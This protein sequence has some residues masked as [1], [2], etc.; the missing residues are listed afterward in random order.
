MPSGVEN[1][2]KRAVRS[3]LIELSMRTGIFDRSLFSLY[4]YMFSPSQL[5]FLTQCL[6]EVRNVPG[7][8]V[9]IGCAHG[10]TTVF[11]RKF[12]NENGIAKDYWALDT[13]GGFVAEHVDYE[14]ARRD[15]TRAIS[16]IFVTNKRSWFE[17]SLK[18]SG[19]DAVNSVEGDATKFDFDRIA[20]IAFALL[21]VDL[22]LPI[23]DILPKL[24]RNL[25]PG[26]IILIDDC[27]PHELW[28]GALAA[29][30]EFAMGNGIERSIVLDKLGVIRK[31]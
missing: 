28:D 30:E 12:M 8:C 19:V 31:A 26:G 3:C 9:E 29:Y 1:P 13:F 10:R 20:P 5:V 22:Y 24:Y 2:F 23:K 27:M 14:V 21:D 18:I 25:S 6:A 16:Q 7:C 17:H 11:L 15:K 4:N